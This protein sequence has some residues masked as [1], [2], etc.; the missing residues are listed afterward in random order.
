MA[1]SALESSPTHVDPLGFGTMRSLNIRLFAQNRR[2]NNPAGGVILINKSVV[3]LE[4]TSL[5]LGF[6]GNEDLMS[7]PV[8][9]FT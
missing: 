1:K 7:L 4:Q 5:I 2:T 3:F 9:K 8:L 6:L